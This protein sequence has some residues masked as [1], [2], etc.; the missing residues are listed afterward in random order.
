MPV[1]L[2][3]TSRFSKEKGR[4]AKIMLVMT[5]EEVNENIAYNLICFTRYGGAWDTG[6][7]RRAWLA[8]FTEEERRA[9]GRLFKQARNWTVG[10]GRSIY[11]ADEPED[12][13]PVAE[14]RR[15]LRVHLKGEV[16]MEERKWILGDNSTCDN[17]LDGIT[18]D[19]VI[20]A[21]HC[22]CR[23]ISRETVTK[24]FFEILEQRLLDMNELL[25]RNID[26]IAEE[27]RKG[28]E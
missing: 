14:A 3:G 25:N 15:L 5:H 23:V 13:P 19:D 12:V 16:R 27:A 21:V 11:R 26:K 2:L 22:N 24:Q 17:L 4:M 20:L 1:W 6:R 18:F 8:D 28:R 9:A 10:R 7:R